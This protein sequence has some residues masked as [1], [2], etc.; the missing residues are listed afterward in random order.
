MTQKDRRATPRSLRLLRERR[1]WSWSDQ[2]RAIRDAART[3]SITPVAR[4]GIASLVRTIARWES[5][6]APV[7]PGERYQLLLAYVFAH[8]G[9]EVAVGPGSDFDHLMSLLPSW[10]VRADRVAELRAQVVRTAT[11]G[12][13]LLAFLTPDLG[14]TLARVLAAP[15]NLTNEVVQ[16]IDDLVTGINA[17]V[18]STPFSRLQVALAPAV[19]ACRGL[20]AVD[21]PDVMRLPLAQAAANAFMVAARMAFESRDDGT[22]A[23]L[24]A[25][26]VRTARDLPTWEQAA[27]R[28]SQALTM[29]Y[30]TRDVPAAR[31]VADAAVRDA[32]RSDS[33]I[34]RSRAHALQAELAARAGQDRHALA[35]LHLAWQE[36]D[37]DVSSDPAAGRF[38]PGYLDG[39]E[40]VCNLHLNRGADAEPQLA[41]SRE[42]LTQPRQTVQRAIVT[43]DLALARLHAE[44]PEAAAVTLHACIDLAAATR[45]RVPA[46]R[47]VD[48]RNRLKPWRGESFI[49]DL[50]EHLHEELLAR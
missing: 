35:A 17:Q 41:R 43:A 18:G 39:F 31:G 4:H 23:A 10:G 15:Q 36:V 47:I 20:L 27:I 33:R 24:Y 5:E 28:T 9:D 19:E 7:I 11:P 25:Q 21:L 49:A 40:G 32:R 48:V 14:Q 30:S 6:D 13:A 8:R 45:A 22:S 29:L 1:G 34:M 37:G 16:Q 44:G 50:D 3:L 2:A 26:A 46:L 38:G 42:S 12:H